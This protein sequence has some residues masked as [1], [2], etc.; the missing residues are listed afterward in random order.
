M[1]K[2]HLNEVERAV[3]ESEFDRETAASVVLATALHRIADEMA[4]MREELVN[5]GIANRI[6]ARD[7]IERTGNL[8]RG[9]DDDPGESFLGRG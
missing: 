3:Y 6:S 8:L 4:N 9:L 2:T 7:I 5:E 1:Q